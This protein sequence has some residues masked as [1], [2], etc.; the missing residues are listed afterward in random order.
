MKTLALWMVVAFITLLGCDPSPGE[1]T[2]G[3]P[4]LL[5]GN[6]SIEGSGLSQTEAGDEA[7][8]SGLEQGGEGTGESGDNTEGSENS[9]GSTEAGSSEGGEEGSAEGGGS[10]SETGSEGSGEGT[11]E[12]SEGGEEGSESGEEGDE[13]VVEEDTTAPEVVGAFSP[14]GEKVTVRFTEILNPENANDAASYAIWG[15]DNKPLEIA[16]ASHEDVFTTLTL[17]PSAVINSDLSYKVTVTNVEDLSGNSINVSK[18]KA[19]IKRPV[20][21]AIIWHQHQPLYHDVLRDELIGPWVRR[22]ATKDYFDM[23]AILGGYPDV[24]VTINL[25]VVLLKQLELYLE[26]LG[27]YV[28]VEANTVDEEGFLAKWEGHTDPWIDLALRD[29]P[30]PETATDTELEMFYDGA[31]SCVSTSDSIMQRFPEYR[32]LRDK[33]P[34]LLNQEDF[35]KL[36]IFFDLAWYDPD[37]LQP[38]GV[39]MPDGTTVD[40]S[41]LVEPNGNDGYVLEQPPSEEISNRLIAESYKVMSNV[42]GI[43]KDLMLDLDTMDGQIEVATTP[44]YHPILPLIYNTNEAQMGQPFDTLPFPAFSYPE[45]ANAQIARSVAYFDQVFGQK[46][47]GMWP[48]EGSVSESV[49]SLF[50]QNGLDWIATGNK[51]LERS[52]SS[53]QPAYY[54][55]RID[56]DT[57]EGSGGSTDDEMS[58]LFRDTVL[59]DKIGFAFQGLKGEDAANILF[60]DV[61]SQAPPFGAKDRLVTIIL[62]GENAWQEYKKE[63]D[64]KGFFHA[65]YGGLTESGKVGEIIT[66]TPYEYIN[67]NP[68][69]GILPHPTTEQPELEPL[70]SGSWIDASFA[71]WIGEG[72]E[73][74]AWGCLLE[75]REDL[76]KSGLPQPNPSTPEPTDKESYLYKVWKAWDEMYAAEGS[77][78]FWW[79]GADMTTPGNND[80]PFDMGFRAH[81]AGVYQFANEALALNGQP[82]IDV[83]ECPPIIQAEPQA[84]EGPFVTA[85]VMDGKFLPNESEWTNEGAFFYD[86]DSG[87]AIKNPNDDIGLVYFGYDDDYFYVALSSNEDM[88]DKVGTDYE[89]NLYFSHKHIIDADA[90]ISESDLALATSPDGEDIQFK[91]GG[92]AREVKLDFTGNEVEVILNQVKAGNKW[93]S[94]DHN[95]LLGGPNNGASVVE[96]AIPFADL[97]LTAKDDPLEFQVRVRELGTTI[98]TAPAV[99]S[100]VVFEDLTQLIFITFEVD[101]TQDIVNMD[102]FVDINNKPPPFGNGIVFITGNQDGLGNW[103]PN[104]VALLDDGKAPDEVANDGKWTRT[105]GMAPGTLLRWKYTSG[106]NTNEGSWGGTEEFPLTERGYDV[107]LDPNVKKVLIR[108]IFADRPAPSGT[109]GPLTI[110][111]ELEE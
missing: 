75:T 111:E 68:K 85:P 14:D 69:R 97:N 101:V 99:G 23:A 36:K 94:Q 82:L 66:V 52:T 45:D 64:G 67:G 81:L 42:I 58:I 9:E 110:I 59:S 76:A 12:G 44:F 109:T 61:L 77:D 54:P 16:S 72:E 79:Y 49:V 56:G 7:G 62:D 86:D 90:G 38:G 60:G 4:I 63:H 27:P 11:E 24:H 29:T 26:R 21:L 20:Y 34:E 87:G 28:D 32:A 71:I 105:F 17:S 103:V 3:D 108:D 83:K 40:L 74:Q 22:H 104:K 15:S 92:A 43:H 5:E 80:T 102:T 47:G 10:G 50:Q 25:T 18:N 53:P 31:W 39:V 1:M 100:K 65:L 73:N 46:P 95:I 41:D 107:P 48:G 37:F 70:F 106:L 88:G 96:L 91:A 93:E 33:N 78:W 8:D 35:L 84:L 2:T 57:V 89:I 30:T 19:T 6:E 51:V 98:D 13:S 55:Y